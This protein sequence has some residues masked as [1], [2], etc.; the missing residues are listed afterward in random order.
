MCYQVKHKEMGI[1][2][3][4]LFGMGF[5]HPMSNEPHQG[6]CKFPTEEVAHEFVEYFCTNT[7]GTFHKEDF[8]VEEF[9]ERLDFEIHNLAVLEES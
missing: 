7:V 6:L 2:Q 3:G 8:I 5:W 4:D 1:F 9:D